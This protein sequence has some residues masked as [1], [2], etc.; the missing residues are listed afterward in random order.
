MHV[1]GDAI[2]ASGGSPPQ[3]PALNHLRPPSQS[4]PVCKERWGC[5]DLGLEQHR[6]MNERPTNIP[7]SNSIQGSVKAMVRMQP[8]GRSPTRASRKHMSAAASSG[9]TSPRPPFRNTGQYFAR[10][11]ST[12]SY[13][14]ESGA[15]EVRGRWGCCA[16][17]LV[18]EAY[19]YRT[20]ILPPNN[21]RR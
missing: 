13:R 10:M 14:G 16:T 4:V 8:S 17:S 15:H 19:H 18:F 3:R 11:A 1:T 21:R 5:G 12:S 9:V 20:R 7:S 6:P 2:S